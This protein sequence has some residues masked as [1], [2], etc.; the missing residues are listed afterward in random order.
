VIEATLLP[1]LVGWGRAR[2][3]IYTGRIVAADEALRMG[4]VEKVVPANA[5]DR[6]LEEWV[7]AMLDCSPQALRAQKEL[8]RQWETLPPAEAAVASIPV[9]ARCFE[10]GEPN[11]YLRKFAERKR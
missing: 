8:F 3:M 5:L 9:F 2:E 4:L 7:S 1:R 10:S 11:A 6:A